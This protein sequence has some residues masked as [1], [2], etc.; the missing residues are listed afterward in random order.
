[1]ELVEVLFGLGGWVTAILILVIRIR[2]E[3]RHREEL[4]RLERFLARLLNATEKQREP[5]NRLVV[6][7]K[8][9]SEMR[10]EAVAALRVATTAAEDVIRAEPRL[11]PEGF[12]SSPA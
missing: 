12:T 4:E 8:P 1:M 11:K 2:H 9:G 3:K 6:L 5:L 10:D 7:S